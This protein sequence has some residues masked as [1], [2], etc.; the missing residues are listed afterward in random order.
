MTPNEEMIL[1][2]IA[3]L[4]QALGE[5]ETAYYMDVLNA[6]TEIL[7]NTLIVNDRLSKYEAYLHAAATFADYAKKIKP[8]PPPTKAEFFQLRQRRMAARAR[9]A[10]KR[11]LPQ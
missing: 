11:G 1:K 5:F 3:R 8:P 7:I 10:A 4:E 6:V 9:R 2:I